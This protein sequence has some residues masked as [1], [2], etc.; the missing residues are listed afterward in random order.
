AFG[1]AYQSKDLKALRAVWPAMTGGDESSFRNVFNS[2]RSITWTTNDTSIRFEDERADVRSTVQVTQRALRPD[3]TTTQT[4][5]YRFRFERRGKGWTLLG[6]E[7][8]GAA[9]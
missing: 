3:T 4:R 7:N 2:Y 9:R 1:Q 5:A 6:V 8:L